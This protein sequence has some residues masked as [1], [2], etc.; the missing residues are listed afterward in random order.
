MPQRALNLGLALVGL[1]A[2]LGLLVIGFDLHRASS[3]GPRWRQRLLAAGVALLVFFWFTLSRGC[4]APQSR[5]QTCYFPSSMRP[6]DKTVECVA[7]RLPLLERLADADRLH[8]AA[9]DKVITTVEQDLAD[10]GRPET[11]NRIPQPDR[12][13]TKRLG[14][15]AR[16]QV[17]A[18]RAR[19]KTGA[20]TLV[21]RE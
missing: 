15:R 11:L 12:A 10:L 16:T 2:V 4:M 1:V 5:P 13:E 8:P 21:S 7:A 20:P 14:E 9:L 6:A 3:S 17:D 18:I 19:Q